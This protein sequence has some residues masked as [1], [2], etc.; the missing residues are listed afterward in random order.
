YQK[1]SDTVADEAVAKID[2]I[3]AFL[4][5]P[6]ATHEGIEKTRQRMREI[7]NEGA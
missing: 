7:V 1:G 2:A 4:R 6:S 5:Q 3:N